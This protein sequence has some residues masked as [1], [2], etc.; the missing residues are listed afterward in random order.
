M[1]IRSLIQQP[2][3]YCFL[4][5]LSL[6]HSYSLLG[7]GKREREGGGGRRGGGAQGIQTD[8]GWEYGIDRE[9]QNERKETR[10]A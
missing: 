9:E 8:R 2:E 7:R 3:S 5:D 10:K 6:L 1:A 4:S